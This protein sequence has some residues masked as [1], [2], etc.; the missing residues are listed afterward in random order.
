[1]TT[2]EEAGGTNPGTGTST[3]T[4]ASPPD[5]ICSSLTA[6][7]AVTGRCRSIAVSGGSHVL[8]GFPS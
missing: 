1:V 5:V 3:D 7:A 8:A 4:G 2:V 6:A